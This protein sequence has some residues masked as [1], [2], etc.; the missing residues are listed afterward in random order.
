MK[1]TLFAG[2]IVALALATC[3]PTAQRLPDPR[4][5]S[6]LGACMVEALLAAGYDQAHMCWRPG[7]QYQT[8][9]SSSG[10]G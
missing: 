3:G 4:Q 2:T 7:S 5:H 9:K 8:V 1:T 6:F 10:S